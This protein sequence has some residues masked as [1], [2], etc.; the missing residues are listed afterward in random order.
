MQLRT[1]CHRLARECQRGAIGQRGAIV[2]A[3]DAAD[4]MLGHRGQQRVQ[5]VAAD[6]FLVR[7]SQR[8]HTGHALP[9]GFQLG[10]VL[11]DL[12]LAVRG[13]AAVV[14]DQ[15]R[16]LVPDLHRS[17]GQRHLGQM[18]T[19]PAHTAGVDARCVA[20]NVVLFEQQ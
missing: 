16:D 10:I 19:Q 13:E 20:A 3:H 2:A 6:Q 12:D 14:I 9:Q 1:E 8:G 4:A 11:R 15:R 7:E 5:L 18:A 17:N